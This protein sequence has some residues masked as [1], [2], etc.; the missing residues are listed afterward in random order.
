MFRV[1]FDTHFNLIIVSEGGVGVCQELEWEHSWNLWYVNR[2][3][4]TCAEVGVANK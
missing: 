4:S 2:E 1:Y 3:K